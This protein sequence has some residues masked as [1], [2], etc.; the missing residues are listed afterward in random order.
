MV[1]LKLFALLMCKGSHKIKA[2]LL[3][4]VIMGPDKMLNQETHIAWRSG[5]LIKILKQLIFF[6]EIFPKKY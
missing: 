4:D 6:S 1:N 2:E 3:F 5:R